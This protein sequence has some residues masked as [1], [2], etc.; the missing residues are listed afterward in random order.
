MSISFEDLII[1]SKQELEVR[2]KKELDII[3]N[4]YNV[5]LK[6]L[7]KQVSEKKEKKVFFFFFSIKEKERL[8]ILE[9]LTQDLTVLKNNIQ[10]IYK[11]NSDRMK[12]KTKENIKRYVANKKRYQ[13]PNFFKE[14]LEKS[15]SYPTINMKSFF[16]S[17]HI[18]LFENQILNY[19]LLKLEYKKLSKQYHPDVSIGKTDDLFKQLNKEYNLIKNNILT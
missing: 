8:A 5:V 14:K 11:I 12:F 3:V 9:K 6:F 13:S 16:I 18:Q 7:E 17:N 15:S 19:K 4:S 10:Y 2:N 1:Y